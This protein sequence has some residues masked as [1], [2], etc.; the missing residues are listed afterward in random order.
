MQYAAFVESLQRNAQGDSGFPLSESWKADIAKMCSVVLDALSRR[1]SVPEGLLPATL[2]RLE[3]EEWVE[4]LTDP[5]LFAWCTEAQK[6]PEIKRSD[7]ER[8]DADLRFDPAPMR[9]DPGSPVVIW[10]RP[11]EVFLARM[12]EAGP[13]S[14]GENCHDADFLDPSKALFQDAYQKISTALKVLGDEAPGFRRDVDSFI[15]AIGLADSRASF[16][17]SSALGRFGLVWFSPRETWPY[18]IWAEELMHE[19]THYI[20]DG[21]GAS[22][23]LLVGEAAETALLPSPLRADLRPAL[24]AFHALVVTGRILTLLDR[25]ER[26]GHDYPA[27][28]ERREILS[29]A[30]RKCSKEFAG[31]I[32][33][34][35]MGSAIYEAYVSPHVS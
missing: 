23:P 10:S 14:L 13:G 2:A 12:R 4:R 1:C 18:Q 17:G 15:R 3:Y 24:G 20:L 16:R 6:L 32:D 22:Q 34:S 7:W 29:G 27:L 25:L 30:L 26:S 35:V 8:L 33:M 21:V 28:A 19:A 9:P 31:A 5:V 11:S